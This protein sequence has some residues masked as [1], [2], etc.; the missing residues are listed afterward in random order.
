[1]RQFRTSGLMSGGWETG[2][3]HSVSYRAHP[4]LYQLAAL[5]RSVAGM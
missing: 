5:I 2:D 4:R 3:C 1:M